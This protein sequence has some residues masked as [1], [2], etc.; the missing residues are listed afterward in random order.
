MIN[1][2][3]GSGLTGWRQGCLVDGYPVD[4]AFVERR[5]AVEVDGWAFH[6]DSIRFRHDPH[7][8]NNLV[9]RGWTV[10][11]F[12]WHDLTHRP[13]VVINDIRAALMITV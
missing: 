13:A 4:F 8:Q 11:R 9:L 3:R 2:L 6:S 5:L 1:L 7:R 12:T 10:L